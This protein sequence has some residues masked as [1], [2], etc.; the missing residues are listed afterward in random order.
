M[1]VCGVLREIYGDYI[2][3]AR[4]PKTVRE[5]FRDSISIFSLA[6]T[7]TFFVRALKKIHSIRDY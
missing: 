3:L 6:T 1:R 5:I 4:R 2:I 7:K